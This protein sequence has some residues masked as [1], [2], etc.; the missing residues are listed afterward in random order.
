MSK[1]VELAVAKLELA[2]LRAAKAQADAQRAIAVAIDEL[3]EALR[4]D[5]NAEE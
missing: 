4:E 5:R 1:R 2:R 3:V